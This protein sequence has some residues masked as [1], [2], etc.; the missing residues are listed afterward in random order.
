M[1]YN[2]R[3]AIAEAASRGQNPISLV[4]SGARAD[5]L[6]SCFYAEVP[7]KIAEIFNITIRTSHMMPD[8]YGVLQGYLDPASQF[9]YIYPQVCGVVDF[10]ED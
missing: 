9:T 3:A 8:R 10:G 7:V 2:I 5:R 4:V 1:F 6:A